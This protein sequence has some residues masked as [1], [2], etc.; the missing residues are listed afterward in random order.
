M[1][2]KECMAFLFQIKFHQVWTDLLRI[3]YLSHALVATAR[4]AGTS[5]ALKRSLTLLL[6]GKKGLYFSL[7]L[8]RQ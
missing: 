1:N 4:M 2:Y 3:Q 5:Y 7:Q 8:N 6:I